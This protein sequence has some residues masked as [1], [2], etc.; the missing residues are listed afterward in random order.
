MVIIILKTV[1]K[2]EILS[3]DIENYFTKGLGLLT[4]NINYLSYMEPQP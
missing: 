2:L 4:L 1:V 3:K